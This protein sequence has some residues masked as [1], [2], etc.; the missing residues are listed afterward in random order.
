MK[1]RG[2]HG[3]ECSA[4]YFSNII[5]IIDKPRGRP[6]KTLAG[7]LFSGYEE[8]NRKKIRIDSLLQGKDD[9]S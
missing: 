1:R 8:D 5:I 4:S 7:G 2:A 9:M 3:E 6:T